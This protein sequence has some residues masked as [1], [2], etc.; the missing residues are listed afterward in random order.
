LRRGVG[1]YRRRGLHDRTELKIIEMFLFTAEAGV[2]VEPT[3]ED[4]SEARWVPVEAAV[5]L[6]TDTAD[7]A[8]LL[9]VRRLIADVVLTLQRETGGVDFGGGPGQ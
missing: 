7:K 6:L 9:R 3:S 5:S 8:F 4:I 1:S 2:H